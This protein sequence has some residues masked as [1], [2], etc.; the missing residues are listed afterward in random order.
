MELTQ[1]DYQR[2]EGVHPDLVAV[3]LRA[4]QTTPID[5]MILEGERTIEK[6]RLLVKKGASKTLRSRHV[7]DMNQCGLA[8]AV[9]L[10]VLIDGEIRWDW[11]LYEDLSEVI[12]VAAIEEGTPVEWGGDWP[13]FRD[14]PHYQLPWKE[15]P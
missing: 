11:P 8:C 3:V 13:R 15:Y 2:L 10:A 5:F 9:D 6:Q 14:G 1:S 7:P 4:T 12:K